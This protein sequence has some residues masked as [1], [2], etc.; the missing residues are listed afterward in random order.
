MLPRERLLA[1]VLGVV[2]SGMVAV[3]I[4]LHPA[5]E[6]CGT[7]Q[8]LGMPPCSFRVAFGRRCPSCGMTTAWACLVRGQ[9][10]DAVR[11]N[12][13]GVLL[14]TAAIVAAPWLLACCLSRRWL[15]WKPN[16]SA[17]AR[18]LLVVAVVTMLDWGWRILNH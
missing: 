1:G 15:G 16:A 6:G 17:V 12:A 2:L 10:G 3:A 11:A 18:A 14:G 5:E 9:L 7:H 4:W 13:G 8:Q